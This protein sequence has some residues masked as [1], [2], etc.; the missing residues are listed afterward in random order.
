MLEEIFKM[1]ILYLL[2][3]WLSNSLLSHYF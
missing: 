1:D 2:N 3:I